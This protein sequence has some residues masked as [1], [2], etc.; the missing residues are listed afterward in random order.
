MSYSSYTDSFSGSLSV[1]D[2]IAKHKMIMQQNQYK[3][4]LE[5][6]GESSDRYPK[7]PESYFG[8]NSI[9]HFADITQKN[10]LSDFPV[11]FSELPD[12]TTITAAGRNRRASSSRGKEVAGSSTP[13]GQVGSKRSRS[14]DPSEPHQKRTSTSANVEETRH[15]FRPNNSFLPSRSFKLF[16]LFSSI[17]QP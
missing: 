6:E 11:T 13:Q 12:D 5:Q 17:T 16:I 9:F 8:D 1:Q 3:Q 14:C 4:S 2:D 10:F 15:L 7:Y